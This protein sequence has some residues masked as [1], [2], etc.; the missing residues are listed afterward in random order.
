MLF[1]KTNHST[2]GFAFP[3]PTD[4]FEG[5]LSRTDRH[6]HLPT[7]GHRG[8]GLIGK[9]KPKSFFAVMYSS[10]HCPTAAVISQRRQFKL[11]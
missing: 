2:Q 9:K 3:S 5:H 6:V 1:M 8:L 10:F 11:N 4:V 7:I